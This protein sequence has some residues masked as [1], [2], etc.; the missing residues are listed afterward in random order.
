[1]TVSVER[2]WLRA[3]VSVAALS[4]GFY[5]LTAAAQTPATLSLG[6]LKVGD[7]KVAVAIEMPRG[8]DQ[9][10]LVIDQTVLREQTVAAG[11]KS[12]DFPLTAPL[13]PGSLVVVR[14]NGVEVN[15]KDGMPL[16]VTLGTADKGKAEDKCE[17]PAVR[18]ADDDPFQASFFLGEVV[19]N[20]APDK[21]GNYQNANE[22]DVLKRKYSFIF[23]FDFDYRLAGHSDSK[24]Q[25]W[26]KGETMHGVRSADV[27]CS[28]KDDRPPLCEPTA[29]NLPD[30]ARY[31]L[32][33]ASS[34][35]VW[36]YPRVEFHT[37]QFGSQSPAAVYAGVSLGFVALDD[38]GS[39]Y[40]SY[41]AAIGLEAKGGSFKN[42]SLEVGWGK[43]QLFSNRLNRLKI[44]GLLSFSA[45][46]LKL[47]PDVGRPF[48][49]MTI[50]NSLGDGADSVRTFFGVDI[51][52]GKIAQ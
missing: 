49:E 37:L 41:H 26:V 31:I 10:G 43:N 40:R 6:A 48:V 22:D 42:S 13:R 44:D 32:R 12:M 21:V 9:I 1:M 11:Q 36:A 2:R 34:L 39:V 35:E 30:R 46:A 28:N 45:G 3:A 7:C 52:L 8:G 29:T 19:D 27:D 51:D 38:A 50:D 18:P 24:V 17:A 16:R 33:N 4:A 20:F 23:G 5:P 15:G 47:S 25:F 14:V